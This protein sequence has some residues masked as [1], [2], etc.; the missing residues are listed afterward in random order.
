MTTRRYLAE[1]KLM[2][3]L[4]AP[5]KHTL[6]HADDLK[7]LREKPFSGLFFHFDK[8]KEDGNKHFKEGEYFEALEYYEQVRTP[9]LIH[10]VFRL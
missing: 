4:P 8:Y 1:R 10:D 2:E 9:I 3:K 6:F 7:K 5:M